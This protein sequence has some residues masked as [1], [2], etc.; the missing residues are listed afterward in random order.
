M[1]WC[2]IRVA[3]LLF[4]SL[5]DFRQPATTHATRR[6][7]EHESDA[8]RHDTTDKSSNPTQLS[9]R[10]AMELLVYYLLRQTH[11][12]IVGHHDEVYVAGEGGDYIDEEA[13]SSPTGGIS[14]DTSQ[15]D[16]RWVSTLFCRFG[17]FLFGIGY[18]S[19]NPVTPHIE[20]CRLAVH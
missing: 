18:A 5:V 1:H 9:P 7:P 8:I 4:S 10:N 6:L 12:T 19:H 14:A 15:R 2:L 16:Y 11:W 20:R 13:A 3:E 17:P